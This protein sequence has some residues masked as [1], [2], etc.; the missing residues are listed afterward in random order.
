M[1]H[2]PAIDQGSQV[3]VCVA[4]LRP[5]EELQPVSPLAGLCCL[6]CELLLQKLGHVA[7]KHNRHLLVGLQA[8]ALQLYL[9]EG[10]LGRGGQFW[11]PSCMLTSINSIIILQNLSSSSS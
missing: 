1:I 10:P 11:L 2:P 7:E 3:Q 6:G 9:I 5:G 4:V 8:V